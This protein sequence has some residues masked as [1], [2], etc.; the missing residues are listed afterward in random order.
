MRPGRELPDYVKDG[1]SAYD[2]VD[3][4][5]ILPTMWMGDQNGWLGRIYIKQIFSSSATKNQQITFQFHNFRTFLWN[6]FFKTNRVSK[7]IR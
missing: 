4:S 6:F 7:K 2:G 3:V 5:T 1:L